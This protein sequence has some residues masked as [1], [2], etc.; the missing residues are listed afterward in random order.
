M[1]EW[2]LETLVGLGKTRIKEEQNGLGKT[3]VKKEQNGRNY[4]KYP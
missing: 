3:Q 2:K 1:Y 4:G